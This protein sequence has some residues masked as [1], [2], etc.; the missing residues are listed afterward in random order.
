MRAPTVVTSVALAALFAF[1]P[2]S[3][4]ADT[5]GNAISKKLFDEVYDQVKA[6]YVDTL[7]D[8]QLVEGAIKGM[9]SSLDPHSSYMDAKEYREMMVTTRGEFGGLGMQVTMENGAV[10][11]ISPIDDTPAAHA[12]IKPGDLI[13]AIDGRPVSELTL[14]EA[15]EKLRGTIGTSVK[16][17]IRREGTDPFELSLTRGDIKVEPVKSHLEG[18]DIAYIRITSFS[19]RASSSLEQAMKTMRDQ[20]GGKLTGVV[21]DLRNNPGGLLDQAVAVSNDFLDSGGIVSIKGRQPQDNRTYNAQ[22]DKDVAR[23]LPVVV[24]ING[25]SASAS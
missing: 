22:A 19:E 7:T 16:L 23:G 21:L 24:L 18:G 25:G 5:G 3:F 6:N 10:K 15:V 9:L 2:T 14:S 20:A 12:G 8:K 11:V 13:L 1:L 4:A 17:M